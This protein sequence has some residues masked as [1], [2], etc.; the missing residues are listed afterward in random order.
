MLLT[1]K[2]GGKAPKIIDPAV[3]PENKSQDAQNCRFDFGGIAPLYDDV[4]QTITDPDDKVLSLYRYFGGIFLRWPSDVDVINPSLR[5]EHRRIFY[6]EDGKFRVIDED[7][8]REFYYADYGFGMNAVYP[9][10]SYNPCPPP[11]TEKPYVSG[12]STPGNP[13][14]ETRAYVY[15]F[16]NKW[17]QEGP[18]SPVSSLLD[19]LDGDLVYVNTSAIDDIDEDYQIVAKRIY[20]I[21]QGSS[22]AV[23][24][25]VV[26]TTDDSYHDTILDQDLDEALAT[27]EWDAP[28]DGI[29]GIISLPNGS[30]CGFVDNVL[31]FSEP[32]YPHAWPVSYQKHTEKT[33]IAIGCFGT[34]VAVLTLGDAYLAVG[35]HPSNVVMEKMDLGMSNMSK[36]GTVQAGDIVIYPSPEGIVVIGSNIRDL[37]TKDIIARKDWEK[38]NPSSILG[39]YW[40]GHYVGFYEHNGKRAGFMLN[41]AT[42]EFSDL[43]FYA[44]AGFYEKGTGHLF[45]LV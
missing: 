40:D 32:Y 34:T 29:T 28:L 2:F 8:F 19:V 27:A 44:R 39:F 37:I 22:G 20:R 17:G 10:K 45:L 25:F 18:P 4:L 35:S 3:L 6:T 38:Y 21:N 5:D 33:I 13:L 42:L 26:E 15:T 31:C 9:T 24:Q 23:Y 36:R 12:T 1:I 16:V 7:T 30:L 43:S 11:P 41:L 14:L